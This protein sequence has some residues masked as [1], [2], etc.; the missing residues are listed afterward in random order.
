MLQMQHDI[1]QSIQAAEDV[2]NDVFELREDESQAGLKETVCA[3]K[4]V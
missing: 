3:L 1:K 2:G 4:R